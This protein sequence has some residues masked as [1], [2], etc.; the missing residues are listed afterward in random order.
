M[1]PRANS[2]G[3]VVRQGQILVEEQC[4]KHS[5]GNGLYYRPVGGTIEFGEHSQETIVREFQEELGVDITVKLHIKC[6]ENIFTVE[7]NM[8]HEITQIYLVEFNNPRLYKTES[9]TVVEG[10]K[11][12]RAIWVQMDEFQQGRKTLY[13]N[14][15]TELLNDILQIT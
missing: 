13:P 11:M 7:D 8:G 1:K 12:T 14:G 10:E 2:L 15:L 4:G 5:Q 6:L 3:I 9:F